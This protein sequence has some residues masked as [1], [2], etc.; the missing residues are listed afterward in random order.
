MSNINFCQRD[1]AAWD[2]LSHPDDSRSFATCAFRGGL[3]RGVQN[4]HTGDVSAPNGPAANID[5]CFFLEEHR[6]RTSESTLATGGG[7]YE[8]KLSLGTKHPDHKFCSCCL[9][10]RRQTR[11]WTPVLPNDCLT[12]KS[13]NLALK[14]FPLLLQ[15]VINESSS[16][17]NDSNTLES[18]L[19]VTQFKTVLFTTILWEI[20]PKS[21]LTDYSI[22][23]L[24]QFLHRQL[25]S[26]ISCSPR[27]HVFTS[28]RWR[29]R[30]RFLWSQNTVKSQLRC[31]S[32]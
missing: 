6:G 4:D 13:R 3:S 25:K 8:S 21:L 15:T 11:F 17:K 7:A 23:P 18:S 24:P 5:G 26:I 14:C 20:V 22:E 19:T 28:G 12:L 1:S 10:S 30:R 32:D 16:T 31:S 29:R 9:F 27:F 2:R